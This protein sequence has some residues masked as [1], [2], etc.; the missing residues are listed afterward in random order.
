L[1]SECPRLEAFNPSVVFVV[2]G[3]GLVIVKPWIGSAVL[4]M[5]GWMGS[6]RRR[7]LDLDVCVLACRDAD[8][9]C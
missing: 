6:R 3:K 4:A 5:Q 9:E 7:R 8:D 2:G 1:S